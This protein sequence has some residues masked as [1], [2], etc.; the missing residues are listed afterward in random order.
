MNVSLYP[1]KV[2]L[3]NEV[4]QLNCFIV[5]GNFTFQAQLYRSNGTIIFAYK[6]VSRY[7]T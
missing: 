2:Q 4:M 6:N 7:S 3:C 5:D 1:A